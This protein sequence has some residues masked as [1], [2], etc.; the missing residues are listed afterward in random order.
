MRKTPVRQ[1]EGPLI[2]HIGLYGDGCVYELNP[3]TRLRVKE[4]FPQAPMIPQVFLGLEKKEDFESW[5][6][7]YFQIVGAM[8]TGLTPDQIRH[9]GGLRICDPVAET[10]IWE[11]RPA[12]TRA[13]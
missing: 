10:T 4:M 9:T 12:V 1:T 7:P 8:L 5:H 13:Q 6:S 2:I 3:L 11:W